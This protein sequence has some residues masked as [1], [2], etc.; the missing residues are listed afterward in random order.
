M[1]SCVVG[2]GRSNAESGIA[3]WSRKPKEEA[4]SRA[5]EE[6]RHTGDPW[7]LGESDGDNSLRKPECYGGLDWSAMPGW[8]G[9]VASRGL[10]GLERA[11][12][13][14]GEAIEG[15]RKMMAR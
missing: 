2:D 1:V 15:K 7:L 5:W 14:V 4:C 10:L 11:L 8:A 13:F 6:W 3:G 9:V 12:V